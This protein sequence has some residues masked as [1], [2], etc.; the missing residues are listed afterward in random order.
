MSNPF[1]GGNHASL[2]ENKITAP[3]LKMDFLKPFPKSG[4]YYKPTTIGDDQLLKLIG[5][6]FSEEIQQQ[7]LAQL[8]EYKKKVGNMEFMD[9]ILKYLN[10]LKQFISEGHFQRFEDLTFLNKAIGINN[11]LGLNLSNIESYSKYK[12]EVQ[13]SLLESRG[14][15]MDTTNPDKLTNIL[16]SPIFNYLKHIVANCEAFKI[17]KPGYFEY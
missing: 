3:I 9:V 11:I 6:G 10:S 8:I 7:K 1:W 2:L 14:V 5:S 16:V 15:C 4:L 12:P 17:S 13:K